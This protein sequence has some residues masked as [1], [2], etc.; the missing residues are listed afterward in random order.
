MDL[1][2]TIED[3]KTGNEKAQ[4]ELYRHFDGFGMSISLRYSGNTEDAV[5]ILNDAFV[6]LFHKLHELK[7]AKY[8]KAWLKRILINT[9]I[10]HYRRNKK[11]K[12]K[13]DLS[14]AELE[15]VQEVIISGITAQEIMNMVQELPTHLRMVFN[16]FVVEGY[17]HKEVAEK[18]GMAE[19]TSRANL[20]LANKLL[21]SNLKHLSNRENAY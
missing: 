10:D 5:E 17:S 16:L 19:G 1:D 20:S 11:H 2:G 9:A 14:R 7:E 15:P 6:K 8:L 18:L 3:C 4:A 21:R 12:N 13:Y